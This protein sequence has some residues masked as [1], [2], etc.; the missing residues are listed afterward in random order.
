MKNLYDIICGLL[1]KN[2]LS[3]IGNRIT[4]VDLNYNVEDIKITNNF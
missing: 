1:D 3:G 4:K 2:Q